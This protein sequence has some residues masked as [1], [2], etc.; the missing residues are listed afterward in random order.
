MN[1]S[2]RAI[3]ILLVAAV[4]GVCGVL[5]LV[6]GHDLL[7]DELR[8]L[9]SSLLTAPSPPLSPT[10][11]WVLPTATPTVGRP[12]TTAEQA[13][14]FAQG[15][16][17]DP[18]Q[19]KSLMGLINTL[20]AAS[21]KLGHELTVGGWEAT[22]Q[23]N[24]RWTV[25]YSFQEG[26]VPK[27]YE[28]LVDLDVAYIKAQN[29]AGDTVLRYLQQDADASGVRPTA[30]PAVLFVGWAVR[31]YYTNWEY[32]VPELPQRLNVVSHLG[33]TLQSEAG[34]VAIPLVL[35]NIGQT[36]KTLRADFYT[37]FSL[38]DL[39]GQE[40]GRNDLNH[41]RQYTRLYCRSRGLP[42]WTE[43][44]VSVARDATISTALVFELLPNAKP[45]YMLEITVYEFSLPHRYQIR[46]EKSGA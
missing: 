19:Q 40:A 20:Q 28:F 36:T 26:A 2:Q 39:S 16:K 27:S 23:A 14:A 41:L 38:K 21:Q 30:T 44:N 43:K 11:V 5:T 22:R 8:P 32:H 18:G 4:I 25:S 31:D 35:H 15:F 10:V 12:D 7:A 3:L 46:L 42:E 29:E 1:R 34:Y 37:R 33:Q 45:P 9:A 13:I 6:V 24:N 17:Y